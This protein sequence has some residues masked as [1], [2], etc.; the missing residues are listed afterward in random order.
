MRLTRLNAR[1][2]ERHAQR[3]DQEIHKIERRAHPSVRE[4]E[5]AAKLKRERVLA[6]DRLSQL[7]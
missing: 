4:M 3:L 1:E 5:V 7:S 6:K 2:L